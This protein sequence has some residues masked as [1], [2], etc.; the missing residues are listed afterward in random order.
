VKKLLEQTCA[1][2]RQVGGD[3]VELLASGEEEKLQ[4]SFLN[5]KHCMG[6]IN[7]NKYVKIEVC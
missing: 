3:K 2:R 5:K 6:I 4:N 1:V 7:G